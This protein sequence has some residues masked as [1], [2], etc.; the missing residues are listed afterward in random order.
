MVQVM[1]VLPPS[2]LGMESMSVLSK[3]GLGP[4]HSWQIV[5]FKVFFFLVE[6]IEPSALY[7]RATSLAL[8]LLFYFKFEI[9][10][11]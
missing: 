6:E 8:S 5:K 11:C 7:D 4:A 1:P 2:A 9:G 3:K 10:S